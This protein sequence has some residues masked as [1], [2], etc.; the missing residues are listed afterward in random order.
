MYCKECKRWY[1]Y[2]WHDLTRENFYCP[3]EQHWLGHINTLFL[4]WA[5]IKPLDVLSPR[6]ARDLV[7]Q[8]EAP[9]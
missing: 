7:G 1:L 3:R 6:P 8:K 5:G 9:R 4:P 2:L